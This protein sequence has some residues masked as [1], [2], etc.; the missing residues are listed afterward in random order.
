M[1]RI[2]ELKHYENV[3][4]GRGAMQNWVDLDVDG[5]SWNPL[6]AALADDVRGRV[7]VVGPHDPGFL[8]ALAERCESL[9]V[10]VRAAQDAGTIGTQVLSA[11]VLVGNLADQVGAD[12]KFDAVIAL[13]DLYRVL[14]AE[15]ADTTWAELAARIVGHAAPGAPVL[16]AI[17][18]ERGL[19]RTTDVVDP[20]AMNL[21]R[22][23]TPFRTW[24]ASRPR[25][26]EQLAA[27]THDLGRPVRVWSLAPTW[28]RVDAIATDLDRSSAA[29]DLLGAFVLRG[30]VSPLPWRSAALADR[31]D[32]VVS[33][34]VVVVDGPD[35]APA[36]PL[37]S[38]EGDWQVAD[39]TAR[40][41]DR[42]V[43]IPEGGRTAL[44]DLIE[45]AA[46]QDTPAMRATLTR[47]Y[48]ELTDRA[49]GGVVPAAYADARLRNVVVHDD[50]VEFLLPAAQDAPLADVAW[51][52][53]ADLLTTIQSY[54]LKHPWPTAMNRTTRLVALGAMAGAPRPDDVGRWVEQV[55]DRGQS[56]EE[57]LAVVM[58]QQDEIK[59]VWAR[60]RWDEKE[61][62][63]FVAKTNVRKAVRYAK[64]Q[65]TN[66]PKDATKRVLRK[67]SK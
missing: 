50:R 45:H 58:R 12:E 41:G 35:A 6:V 30:G 66:L 65:G 57:L 3:R 60:M 15:S 9:T 27:W 4:L 13:D 62:A 23:W 8:K 29:R 19:H 16:L 24:D 67:L 11:Q 21:D 37:R 56:R 44:I 17:E 51:S 61:Y 48:R 46:N 33:G 40:M 43:A 1:A 47:W 20:F 49:V 63:T 53:L 34:W 2:V 52:A 26:P 36:G 7:L 5:P 28:R 10:V 31:I 42:V 55:R 59:S 64:K 14:S 32:E 39:R 18:N 38:A 22:D 25:T 54:G